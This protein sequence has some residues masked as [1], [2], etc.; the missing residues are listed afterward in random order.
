[1]EV[2][3]CISMLNYLLYYDSFKGRD[4]GV[5]PKS[6]MSRLLENGN[7]SS[8]HVHLFQFVSP[9]LFHTL[10]QCPNCLVISCAGIFL[11][12]CKKEGIVKLKF[13]REV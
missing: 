7:L 3:I 5:R 4:S 8:S 2:H 11:F 13:W 9:P 12:P 6:L 1:M 10:S